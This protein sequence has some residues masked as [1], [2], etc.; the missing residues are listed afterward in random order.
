MKKAHLAKEN[1]FLLFKSIGLIRKI[2][3][4]WLLNV[5]KLLKSIFKPLLCFIGQEENKTVE[6][7]KERHSK[8][9][10]CF[11]RVLLCGSVWNMIHIIL[12]YTKCRIWTLLKV[13]SFLTKHK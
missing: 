10:V 7:D 6:M 13:S 1:N 5:V 2:L 11:A 12:S 9:Q 4:S 8:N 3:I